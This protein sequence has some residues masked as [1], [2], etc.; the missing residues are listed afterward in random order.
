MS[1]GVALIT[2][3]C[4]C[5]IKIVTFKGGHLYGKSDFPYHE[6]LLLKERIPLR[7]VPIL[8]REATEENHCLIQ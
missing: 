1:I 2:R 7:E 5:K 4:T 6:N 8:K 3:L